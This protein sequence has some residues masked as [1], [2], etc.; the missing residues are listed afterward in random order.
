VK[1]LVSWLPITSSDSGS[2]DYTGYIAS[3]TLNR[4]STMWRITKRFSEFAALNKTMIGLLPRG[5]MDTMLCKFPDDA[6]YSVFSKVT[7][8]VRNERAKG[9]SSSY[10]CAVNE[11]RLMRYSCL[12]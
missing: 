2:K 12:M 1:Y 8:A 7:D 11:N 5:T 4:T 6:R 3:I 9:I 10:F